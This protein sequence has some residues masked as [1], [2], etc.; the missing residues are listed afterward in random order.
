MSVS[1]VCL[2]LRVVCRDQNSLPNVRREQNACSCAGAIGPV[3]SD[4]RAANLRDHHLHPEHAVA[5]LGR[6][7]THADFPAIH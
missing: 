4:N 1:V 5:V 3:P 2:G 7:V 6:H